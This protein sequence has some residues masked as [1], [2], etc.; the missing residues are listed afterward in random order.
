MIIDEEL[1]FKLK[2][3]VDPEADALADHYLDR[4]PHELFHAV[5]GVN[6]STGDTA[7]ERVAAWLN[8]RPELPDFADSNRLDNGVRFFQ[9]WGV[10]LGIGLF[11]SSLPLAYASH[12]GAQVLALTARLETDAK[13]RVL[14]SAQFLL[15]V[16]APAALEPGA[17][18]Y[19][20]ARRVR[21]MHA[22][23]RH[24]ILSPNGK[25]TQTEDN[26]VSPRWDPRWGNPINQQHL[27]GA[28]LSFSSSLLHVLDSLGMD[29]DA[30]GAE[31]YCHL[32][33]VVGGLLGITPDVLPLD[34]AQM[35]ELE[36]MIRAEN[37]KE[38]EAGQLLTSALIE[39]VDSF[40]PTGLFR[41]VPPALIR[42]FIG[43]ETADILAVPKTG[44]S[45]VLVSLFALEERW[46]SRLRTK[47]RLARG[48]SRWLSVRILRGFVDV[49]R[50]GPRP[51]FNIPDHLAPSFE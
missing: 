21:L 26:S 25:I 6:H 28:M 38:S 32:W 22:G 18:G 40:N 19:E 4:P 16:T 42:T 1:L 50:H 31:D 3:Q 10:E 7:D 14:E 35:D 51:A 41:G 24:M 2:Y 43:E 20:S 48:V 47:S 15:D 39:L 11:L 44:A 17:T 30:Q 9:E 13:R 5:L 49:T 29:Y 12:D 45:R 27:L 23:V 46:S 36:K 34:R 33:N 37:E 8:R